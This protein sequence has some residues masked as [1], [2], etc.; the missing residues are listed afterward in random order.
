MRAVFAWCLACFVPIA[1]AAEPIV[2][3]PDFAPKQGW[4]NY[5][6]AIVILLSIILVLA[7]K[8]KTRLPDLAGCKLIEKKH[9]GNKTMVYIV[10][11]Q[12]QRFLLA[13]NQQA[14]AV[15]RIDDEVT[16]D[17]L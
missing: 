17:I 13:D 9:L 15:H 4:L 12:Q 7:K 16:D 6:V 11:Y 10:E 5:G 3:K 1:M 14:L 8:H 2:F